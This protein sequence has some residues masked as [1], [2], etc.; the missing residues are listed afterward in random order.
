[1]AYNKNIFMNYTIISKDKFVYTNDGS[2]YKIQ[3]EDDDTIIVLSKK[4]RFISKVYHF[5]NLNTYC[6]FIILYTLH[7]N[8]I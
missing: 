3:D 5:F 8:F 7:F 4:L 2:I 6:I 1:M